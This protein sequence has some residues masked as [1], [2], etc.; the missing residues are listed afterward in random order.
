MTVKI[1]KEIKINLLNF[2]I[3][4][5]NITEYL[6]TTCKIAVLL[7]SNDTLS[8]SMKIHKSNCHFKCLKGVYAVE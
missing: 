2:C 7:F 8:E 6:I 5:S 4:G 3:S 1:V